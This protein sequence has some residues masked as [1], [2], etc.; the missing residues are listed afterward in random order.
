MLRLTFTLFPLLNL[1]TSVTAGTNLLP[2]VGTTFDGDDAVVKGCISAYNKTLDCTVDLPF[3]RHYY[4]YE[5]TEERLK[6]LCTPQCHESVSSWQAGVKTACDK[7][8]M[9]FIF[10]GASY[11]GSVY[12]EKLSYGLDMVCMKSRDEKNYG[13]WCQLEVAKLHTHLQSSFKSARFSKDKKKDRSLGLP[14][15]ETTGLLAAYPKKVLCSSCFLDRLGI[16][17]NA[18]SSN[19]SPALANDYAALGKLCSKPTKKINRH[20]KEYI[21]SSLAVAEPTKTP[22]VATAKHVQCK[23]QLV[24]F[25]DTDTPLSLSNN[26]I[27]STAELLHANG[28]P[29]TAANILT[30]WKKLVT[31]K[32]SVCMPPTCEILRVD[33]G[34]SCEDIIQSTRNTA[35]LFFSW[36][37]HL[38]GDCTTGLAELQNV[39]VGPPGGRYELPNP[40]FDDN[41]YIR[42]NFTSPVQDRNS[43]IPLQSNITATKTQEAYSA[44]TTLDDFF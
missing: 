30:P 31:D 6:A 38:I 21:R 33:K 12:T 22:T 43:T 16:Q 28:I 3:V 35:T 18:Y 19:W 17:A 5:W 34:E 20:D 24:S 41:P 1:I 2:D 26:L 39:C 40:V 37:P 32:Y 36:N 8:D 10:G 13:D 11:K 4:Q 29:I 23:G 9:P 44:F 14:S 42:P 27:V 7:D 25:L 15:S